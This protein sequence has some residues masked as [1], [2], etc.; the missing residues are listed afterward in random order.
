[1][2]NPT[3]VIKI[4]LRGAS[5]PPKSAPHFFGKPFA[6]TNFPKDVR[7]D[8]KKVKQAV[9]KDY[10]FPSMLQIIEDSAK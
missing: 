6:R 9:H 5:K 10:D 7:P 8:G 3:I 2:S 4:I 1:M